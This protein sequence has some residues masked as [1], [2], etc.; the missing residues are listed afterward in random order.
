MRLISQFGL[1]LCLTQSF[2]CK[3]EAKDTVP[4]PSTLAAP[5]LSA[6]TTMGVLTDLA[7][8]AVHASPDWLQDDLA[9][10]LGSLGEET[11]DEL[12]AT[13]VD[14]D[15]H[16]LIDEIAFSIA[17]L[18]PEVLEDDDFYAEFLVV[19]AEQIYARDADL[20]YVELVDEG[21]P[22]VDSDFYTTATYNVEIDGELETRTI[23]PEIYYWYLVH[24][25]ME[26]EYPY[27]I[28]AWETCNS[29]ECPSTPEDGMHWREFLWDAADDECPSDRECPTISEFLDEDVDVLW[30]GRAYESEDNGA[31]GKLIQWQASAITFGAGDE[32]P[33]QPNRVYAVGCGNCGEWAD[34]ATAASR[35][36]LIPAHNV[37][38]FANDHTWNE[39]WDD[40]WQQWEPVNTYVLHYTYYVDSNG[41]YS[42]TLDGLDNDC[43][44]SA[45]EGL[46]AQPGSESTDTS[47]ADADG[48]SVV[49]GDCDDNNS[50]VY[51]GAEEDESNL[52]D[53]DCDGVATVEDGDTGTDSAAYAD[54]DGDGYT[55][56]DGD[57]NDENSGIYPG[58]DDPYLSTN[59]LFA[60]T[61]A[62]GDSFI[63]NER[64][65]A[66]GTE[67]YLE[68]NVVDEND[69][70][71]DGAIVTIY[72]NWSVYGY[73]DSPAWAAEGVTD[74]DGNVVIH[75]G[76]ANP[77][78]YS[79]ASEA[80]FDP[81][82]GYFY[83][84]V[85][86]WTEAGE[87]YTFSPQVDGDMPTSLSIEEVDLAAE[88]ER[89]STRIGV[90]LR[91]E[92]R[93]IGH[94]G[95]RRLASPLPWVV[96]RAGDTGGQHEESGRRHRSIR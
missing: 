26:D 35:T 11:Q 54:A 22:G 90:A 46:S 27:F 7:Q 58:A 44:G 63:G 23:E 51:P 71:V 5:T 31:I 96:R 12:A 42:R 62:R 72:G 59:R 21:E 4:Q 77:Y 82:E 16:Y 79:V 18:S 60:I 84:D 45:D 92:C 74:P 83:Q 53:D 28:D 50:A 73:P 80:G 86:T 33:I 15:D 2:A 6:T 41:D 68:F 3:Q 91:G 34:M 61:D 19:N 10:S 40:G 66:Y 30:E 1:C 13:I 49:D 88:A 65:E 67:S 85:V 93:W 64:T 75:V 24:P 14:L 78:G 69:T 20:A 81:D 89:I 47:D 38:A 9:I 55:I 29:S 87:T 70:P 57:C 95:V 43:D 17:N 48:F 37:G 32:R 36:A 25:R 56:E 39:F 52:Y 76:E 94:R 8:D